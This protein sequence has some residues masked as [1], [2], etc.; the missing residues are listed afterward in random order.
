[1]LCDNLE[2]WDGLGG[3]KEVQEE[4]QFSSVAQSC[5][6]PCNLMD[7]STPGRLVHHQHQELIQT[8]VH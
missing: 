6:T 3:G 4:V 1:M 2:D 7:R 8:H 5:P